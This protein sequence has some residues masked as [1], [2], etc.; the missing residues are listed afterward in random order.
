MVALNYLSVA[1]SLA[2]ILVPGSRGQAGITATAPRPTQSLLVICPTTTTQYEASATSTNT[3]LTDTGIINLCTTMTVETP[4]PPRTNS[5]QREPTFNGLLTTIMI[6]VLVAFGTVVVLLL[7]IATLLVALGCTCKRHKNLKKLLNQSYDVNTSTEEQT[8]C[9]EGGNEYSNMQN[10]MMSDEIGI[11]L[12]TDIDTEE[13]C[14]Y[15][16]V[17]D[18]CLYDEDD[19]VIHSLPYETVNIGSDNEN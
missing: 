3:S 6:A 17:A 15:G 1:V 19:Y 10:P 2:A 5:G 14:C 13:N 4:E 11:E 16:Q 9:E 8:P 12:R 18:S 7:V